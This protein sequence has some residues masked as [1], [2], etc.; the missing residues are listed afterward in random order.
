MQALS[1]IRDC[2]YLSYLRGCLIVRDC[3]YLSYLNTHKSYFG[4]ARWGCNLVKLEGPEINF[5]RLR[6]GP[7]SSWS[8]AKL[9]YSMTKLRVSSHQLSMESG[10]WTKPNST[11]LREKHC[12]FC[13]L[14]EDEYHFVL[15]CNLYN[16]L[17]KLIPKYYRNCPNM[18]KMYELITLEIAKY[19]V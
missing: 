19:L 9:R 17:R 10:R 6:V 4:R 13:N 12:L 18:F 8:P 1:D 16:T 7:P 11:P 3:V 14:L 15:K 5:D 2:V